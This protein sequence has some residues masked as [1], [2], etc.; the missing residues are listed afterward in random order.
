VPKEG[1]MQDH[2]YKVIELV[3]SSNESVQTAIENAIARAGQTIRNLDWFVVKEVRG[4]IQDG[5][6]AWYQVTVDI[7]F[8][9]ISPDDVNQ[10]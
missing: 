9:V 5:S 3:G 1:I 4:N 2:T 6:V 10:G 8:R 7:G